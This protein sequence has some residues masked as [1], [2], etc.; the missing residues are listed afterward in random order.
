MEALLNKQKVLF[1]GTIVP[2]RYVVVDQNVYNETAA[3]M[4]REID[5]YEYYEE[6][7]NEK[8]KIRLLDKRFAIGVKQEVEL[9]FGS[10]YT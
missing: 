7:N 9:M 3:N 10:N 6:Q 8:R 1:D 2:E 5:A 4:R